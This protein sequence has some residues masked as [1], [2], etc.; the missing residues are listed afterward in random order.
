L[1]ANSNQ[2]MMNDIEVHICSNSHQFSPSAGVTPLRASEAF[3][4]ETALASAGRYPS[5]LQC[6]SSNLPDAHPRLVR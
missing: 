2:L 4:A 5:R 6:H 1:H 3:I